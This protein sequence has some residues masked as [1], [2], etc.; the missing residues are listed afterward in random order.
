[1]AKAGGRYY[2]VKAGREGPKVYSTWD[3]ALR[4][5]DRFPGA[6]QKSF[7]TLSEAEDWIGVPPRS[8]AAVGGAPPIQN[9]PLPRAGPELRPLF[10]E[11]NAPD[12][13]VKA[14]PL[15]LLSDEQ[16]A[17]LDMVK[18]GKNVFFTGS[19]GTGKSVLLREIIKH[20]RS[21]RWG[22]LA[23]TAS[24]G[25]ASVNIGGSTIHSWAGIG[26]G[27]ETAQKLVGKLIGQEA[28]WKKKAARMPQDDDID[29]DEAVLDVEFQPH[30]KKNRTVERWKEV[31]T[32]I[33][34]E[35]SMIDGLLF[36]KLEFIA[37][38]LRRNS[39]P[40]GGIQ[41]VLS[42]DFCQLPPVPD[43]ANGTQ[44]PPTFAFDAKSWSQC[45]GKPVVLTKV[46]RQKDQAFVDMLNGMRFGHLDQATINKFRSLSRAV[47]YTDGIEP[48]DL[49]PTR[50]EVD[51]A[52]SSRLNKIR[53]SARQY[54]AT[55]APGYDA[56]GRPIPFPQME[57]LLE[58]LVAPKSIT[59]KVGAQVMLIK[60]M[61]Q[62]S[63]VN[64]SLGRVIAFKTTREATTSGVR[65]AAMEQNRDGT[66]RV[67]ESLMR[68]NSLWPVVKFQND[69][70]MLC[71][72]VQFEVNDADGKVEAARGQVPLIL[73]W[74]LSIH[75]SQGQTL[76]RV[77]VNLGRIFE[78]GQAYVA[79]SRATSMEK[80]QV[81]NFDP[82]KVMAH[83]RVMAWMEE[84][85]GAR[86]NDEIDE[87][88]E[89]WADL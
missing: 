47:T 43:R 63:L 34:D 84:Q 17:V 38:A 60:N 13:A 82:A 61:E 59:L 76:E 11:D 42:G 1:M 49:F 64:G 26:L 8:G 73:A 32:L 35:I 56:E 66:P 79:L 86:Y 14:P 46:F 75:K 2:A 39:A 45:V 5:T 68:A 3:E 28:H 52:N 54:N 6:V 27:K 18:R 65:I 20:C 40:F 7:K 29:D 70:Q 24:T 50:R 21:G 81:L 25:I 31:R 19:A 88:L 77:R 44:Q 23:I 69:V 33:I 9:G 67:P 58:R 37:R 74:A 55:D 83:P 4:N 41:L 78:K 15:I 16:R 85:T 10:S 72:P 48:T 36:D 80:L 30:E 87:T 71:V 51:A 22:R 12:P 57:R 62:G 89:F 53:E